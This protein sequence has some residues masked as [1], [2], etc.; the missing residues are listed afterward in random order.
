VRIK[1]R[2]GLY[3]ADVQFPNGKWAPIDVDRVNGALRIR[4]VPD[5]LSP[6]KPPVQPWD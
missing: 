1:N 3:Q 4:T 2:S 6:T 5:T